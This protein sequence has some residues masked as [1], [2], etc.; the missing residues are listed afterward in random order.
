MPR[1]IYHCQLCDSQFQVWHGMREVQ[2]SCENCNES[3]CV[4]KIPQIVNNIKAT[5][6]EEKVGQKTKE[7]IKQNAELLKNMKTEARNQAY[8]D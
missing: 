2:E 5:T 1:Y 8:E 3:G 6:K 4:K 7:Y